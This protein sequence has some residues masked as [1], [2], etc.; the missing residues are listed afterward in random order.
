MEISS[1]GFTLIELIMVMVLISV[2]AIYAAP[3]FNPDDYD[4]TEAASEVIEA[5]RYTQVLS[6]EHSG[7]DTDADSNSDFYCMRMTANG[8][9]V[10]LIDNNSL[11]LATLVADPVT[12]GASYTQS[13]A[14][15]AI[16]LAPTVNDVCFSSQGEPVNTAGAALAADVTITVTSGSS[17]ATVTV[18]E[19][20][21]FSHR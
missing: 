13:W 4:V 12:G 2:I 10:S 15:G 1:R 6:M 21:G 5:L 16:T 3:R 19:I 17:N 14:A 20:T 18:E 11:P 7:M 9:T 8:Y